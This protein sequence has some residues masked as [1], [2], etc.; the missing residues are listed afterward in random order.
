[1]NAVADPPVSVEAFDTQMLL[2]IQRA[3][4][5]RPADVSARRPV[6]AHEP[7]VLEQRRGLLSSYF[8]TVQSSG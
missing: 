1:M 7:S 8:V 3:A 4:R 5:Y 2:L 6:L